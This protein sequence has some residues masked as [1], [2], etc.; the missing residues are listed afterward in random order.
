MHENAMQRHNNPYSNKSTEQK[1]STITILLAVRAAAQMQSTF[2]SL[3]NNQP[4]IFLSVM[5]A[6]FFLPFTLL[7][8]QPY[9]FLSVMSACF[10]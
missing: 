7:N 9:I 4:N 1:Y 5:S 10:F 2:F 6:C 8:N 3:L